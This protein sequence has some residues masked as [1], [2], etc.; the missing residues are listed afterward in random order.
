MGKEVAEKYGERARNAV[1]T[2]TDEL[3]QWNPSGNYSSSKVWDEETK[4]PMLP[5]Q[6]IEHMGVWQPGWVKAT[7][8]IGDQTVRGFPLDTSRTPKQIRADLKLLGKKVPRR[9]KL[10]FQGMRAAL[11]DDVRL[12]ECELWTEE[13]V[14]EMVKDATEASP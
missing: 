10:H 4:R 6:I 9:A 13:G 3:R 7:V 11:H 8:C 2:A 5:H 1:K 12:R 14:M